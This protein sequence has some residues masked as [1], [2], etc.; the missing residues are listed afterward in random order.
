MKDGPQD[1][2]FASRLE[3]IEVGIDDDGDKITSC[4][5]APVEGLTPARGESQPKLAKGAKIALAAL[6]EAIGECGEVPP[7]SN[8]IPTN[9]K[10]VTIATWRDYSFRRG[11]CSSDE[12]RAK[13]MA[14]QRASEGLV[15]A[16]SA[17]IWEPHVWAI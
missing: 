4:V 12:P 17:A 11:I 8:H 13:R 5:I 3:V 7:A 6:H 10:C 14:F 1:Q 15:A 16:K 9:K 2:D